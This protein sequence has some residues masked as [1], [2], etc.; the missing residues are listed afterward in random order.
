M[1]EWEDKLVELEREG[2]S[3]NV[4]K[5]TLPVDDDDKTNAFVF[6]LLWKI[7]LKEL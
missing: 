1:E 4:T 2:I 7:S 3:K 6:K 5:E